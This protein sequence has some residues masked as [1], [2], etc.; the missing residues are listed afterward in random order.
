[1]M[2][3]HTFTFAFLIL[4]FL[5]SLFGQSIDLSHHFEKEEFDHASVAFTVVDNKSGSVVFEHNGDLSLIPASTIK[6]ITTFSSLD[7]LKPDYKFKTQIF[8]TGEIL[9]D[10]TLVG[11]I[12][13]KGDGDPSLGSPRLS[14]PNSI[15]GILDIMTRTI[16]EK[17]IKCIDGNVR[18]DNS[19]F[20]DDPINDTWQWNDLS[21]YYATGTWAFNIHE[22]FY[23]IFFKRTNSEY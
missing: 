16:F 19:L 8:Y 3:K 6:V 12:V 11:D 4:N 23:N 22:N 18:V 2:I 7:L 21:N 1:M 20:S 14:G 15:D 13:I 10:G 9:S 17:G 5:N